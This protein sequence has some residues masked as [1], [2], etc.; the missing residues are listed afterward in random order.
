MNW[1]TLATKIL[2]AA[3]LAWTGC[4]SRPE[5]RHRE[6]VRS[7]TVVFPEPA[8]PSASE[9]VTAVMQAVPAE[10]PA[11]GTFELFVRAAIASAHHVYARVPEDSPFQAA[12]LELNLPPGLEALDDWSRSEPVQRRPGE[13]VYTGSAWFRRRLRVVAPPPDGVVTIRGLLH[14][15]AC[16][17]ELCWPP[18]VLPLSVSL[19]AAYPKSKTR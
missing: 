11:G 19:R 5:F 7:I 15:Q 6:A 2:A 1:A 9:P 13:W 8:T 4:A 10:I 14:F 3:V 16:N 17:E 12:V 18:G